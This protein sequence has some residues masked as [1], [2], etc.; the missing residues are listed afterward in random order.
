LQINKSREL[1]SPATLPDRSPREFHAGFLISKHAFLAQKW[2]IV[3]NDGDRSSLWFHFQ[4]IGVLV[5]PHTMFLEEY[6]VFRDVSRI[7]T[8]R[9]Y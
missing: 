6:P 9:F 5:T 1:S 7:V 2:F 4:V 8:T 3:S